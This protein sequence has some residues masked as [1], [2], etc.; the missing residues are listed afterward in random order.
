VKHPRA[1]G[2]RGQSLAT[3]PDELEAALDAVSASDL[4][5]HGLVLETNLGPVRTSSVGQ[6]TLDGLDLTLAY[7]GA[8]RVTTYNKGRPAYGGSDLVCVRGGWDAL[9]RL[10]GI[11]SWDG[12]CLRMGDYVTGTGPT[13]GAAAAG[14]RSC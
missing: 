7:H 12:G 13:D 5:Q 4:A 8:Q 1:S 2:G 9:G 14:G 10:C 3:S 11:G 6:V